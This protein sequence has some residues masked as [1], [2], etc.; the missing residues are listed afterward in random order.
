[1]SRSKTRLTADIKRHAE[2]IGVQLIRAKQYTEGKHLLIGIHLL[3]PTHFELVNALGQAER[4]LF[5]RII[6]H[7]FNSWVPGAMKRRS[8]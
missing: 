3:E 7:S 4:D 1:M 5:P 2:A 6:I 8:A